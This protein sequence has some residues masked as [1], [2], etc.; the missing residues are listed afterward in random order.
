[1]EPKHDPVEVHAEMT[2][3]PTMKPTGDLKGVST[4]AL[5]GHGMDEGPA[6][7]LAKQMSLAD[8]EERTRGMQAKATAEYDEAMRIAAEPDLATK[9]DFLDYAGKKTRPLEDWKI[10]EQKRRSV[11]KFAK[12]R[13]KKNRIGPTPGCTSDF[14]PG[15]T[16]STSHPDYAD[17][18]QIYDASIY[19]NKT[20]SHTILYEISS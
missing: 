17:K 7:D 1:M 3:I 4:S 6:L 19:T 2:Q 8:L 14:S 12:I 18:K 9:R 11:E 16:I 13:G 10:E 20:N 15:N 5:Q